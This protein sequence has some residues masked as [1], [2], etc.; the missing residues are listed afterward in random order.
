MA[1]ETENLQLDL[2]TVEKGVNAVYQDISKGQYFVTE[3]NR[4]IAA[5]L[6]ITFEWSDWRNGVIWWIQSVYVTKEHRRQGI[7]TSLYR[8]ARHHYRLL[9]GTAT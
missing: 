6:M 3:V 2:S 4:E 8:N 5:S 9:T 1:M 7:Y